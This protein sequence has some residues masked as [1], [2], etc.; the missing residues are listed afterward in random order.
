MQR[1]F[2]PVIILVGILVITVIVGGAYYFGKSKSVK[3]E[4]VSSPNPVVAS[5]TPQP[6]AISQT[7]SSSSSTTTDET[8]NWKTHIDQENNFY[9]KYPSNWLMK[10][11]NLPNSTPVFQ[12]PNT[13]YDDSGRLAEGSFVFAYFVNTDKTLNQLEVEKRA[14]QPDKNS[15]APTVQ[16]INRINISGV[17]VLKELSNNGPSALSLTVIKDGKEIVLS[18]NYQLNNIE[19]TSTCNQIISTF[20]FTQ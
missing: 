16:S 1:G 10:S 17:D 13:Q 8:A 2:T 15:D 7:I 5:Q 12:K 19:G 20:K 4:A 9:F 14:Y 11:G 6:T 18:C 3:P